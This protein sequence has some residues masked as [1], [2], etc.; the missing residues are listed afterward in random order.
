MK[1]VL[2]VMICGAAL[3]G[4]SNLNKTQNGALL[5]G[6]AGAGIGQLAGGDTKATLIGS[7]I[8]AAGGALAGNYAETQ[9]QRRQQAYRQGYQ[10]GY[11]QAQQSPQTM[12]YNTQS[13]A[14]PPVDSRW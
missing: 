14:P 8:G 9:D 5:G 11:S 1:K 10:S 6:L 2:A 12:S 4:C 13:T 3:V 7:G